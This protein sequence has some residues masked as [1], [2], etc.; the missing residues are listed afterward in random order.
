MHGPVPAHAGQSRLDVLDVRRRFPALGRF[1]GAQP[2]LF[3]DAPGGTQV[4]GSVIEAMAR[5]LRASNANTGGAF[6]TSVETDELVTSA[7]LAAADLIGGAPDEVAFG[8][9]MTTLAFGLSRALARTLRPG[10]ELVLTALDHDANI[11]PWLVAARDRGAT[12]RWVDVREDDCTLDLD[13][14]DAAVGERTRLVAFTLAANA[15]GT[16]TPAEEIVARVRAAS[17]RALV[18]ADAVHFAQH[19]LVDVRALGVD[20]L[21]CSAY[22]V[23]GPHVGLMWA[24]PDALADLDPDRVRPSPDEAPCRWETGTLNHEGLAGFVAAVDYLAE[25]G[26]RHGRADGA[27]RRR[28]VEAAFD[29]IGEHEADLARR[30]IADLGGIEGLR[31]FGIQRPDRV[32]ERTPTFALRVGDRSP[33]EVAAALAG[34][35]IFVWDGNYF[36]LAIMERLRLE[37]SGGAVRVGF[38]HYHTLDEVDR[39]AE[40]LRRLTS[41]W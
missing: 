19:R 5:Y 20:V 21:F 24:R 3:A 2:A 18:A 29:V 33:R 7:R 13:S 31:L 17:P 32:A 36:A 4:P 6:A 30:F 40:E 25:L 37:A 9:N 14:L 39:V 27:S 16:V 34:R 41:G 15:V 38:C 11:S 28:A 1:V 12:V 26:A 35:G 22:K 8:A 10:D 23:F